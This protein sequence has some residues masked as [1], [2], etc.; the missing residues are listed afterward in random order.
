M[1]LPLRGVE[2]VDELD[3]A[4]L[5]GIEHERLDSLKALE[6]LELHFLDAFKFHLIES[7]E[8][9]FVEDIWAQHFEVR[10]CSGP[11]TKLSNLLLDSSRTLLIELL[12][13][14]HRV[15]LAFELRHV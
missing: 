3:D 12:E 6:L 7:L 1:L 10:R 9:H 8:V 15:E 4:H 13:F 2:A 14:G 5:L 11:T